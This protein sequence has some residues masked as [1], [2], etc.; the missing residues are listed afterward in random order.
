MSNLYR[1]DPR[2]QW[3][4]RNRLHP[5]HVPEG[6]L[7]QRGPTGLLRKNVHTIGFIGPNGLKRIDR[8]GAADSFEQL[9]RQS[10][11]GSNSAAQEEVVLPLHKVANPD[12]YILVVV[13][14]VSGRLSSHDRDTLGL[15]HKLATHEAHIENG[16]LAENNAAFDKGI[17]G[18]EVRTG[19]GA[20]AGERTGAVVA[21][22]FDAIT[23]ERLDITGIDRLVNFEGNEYQH[24]NPEQRCADLY[25]L[26]NQLNPKHVLFPDSIHGGADLGRRLAAKLNTTVA[27]NVWKVNNNQIV[28]RGSAGKTDIT[29]AITNIMLVL[30]ECS[31]PV[32]DTRHECLALERPLE[33]SLNQLPNINTQ[34]L[35]NQEPSPVLEQTPDQIVESISQQKITDLGNVS[36]NPND[37][38]L[39]EAGFILSGGNGITD[40]DQFHHAAAILGATEG[41]SRVAVDD[42]FMPRERQVGATGTWVTAKVYIAVG[43]SGAIQHMQGIAQCEKVIAVNSD[44]SCDMVKR[45]DLS[46]IGDSQEILAAL[47]TLVTEQKGE[48]KSDLNTDLKG[49][50]NNQSTSTSDTSGQNPHQATPIHMLEA[51]HA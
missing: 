36:V 41:A 21:V 39:A 51:L 3:I 47:L 23:E 22:F 5:L 27:S 40:W 26:V 30:E 2:A 42:G 24:Y 11:Q 12:F 38:N 43:I 45:A 17:E 18:N 34:Y 7:V 44:A 16:V 50:K 29:R 31:E 28:C 1:R 46:A 25:K 15:A 37:I 6:Q 32:S 33:Q 35:P 14:G 8:S 19:A 9:N 4:A 13:D 10:A 20:S 48:P 49:D